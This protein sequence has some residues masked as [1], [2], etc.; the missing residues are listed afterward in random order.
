VAA[1][2]LA[3]Q[4]SQAGAP[5]PSSSGGLVQATSGDTRAPAMQVLCDLS[6]VFG[7]WPC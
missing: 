5:A 3:R 6:T 2:D 7:M 1:P 4:P